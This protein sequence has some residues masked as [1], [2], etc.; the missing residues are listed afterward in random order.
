[1]RRQT[2]RVTR[3]SKRKEDSLTIDVF[4]YFDYLSGKYDTKNVEFKIPEWLVKAR[5]IVENMSD[6]DYDEWLEKAIKAYKKRGI[7]RNF[8]FK[9]YQ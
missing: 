8:K 6:D 3:K 4:D 9:T 7:Q 1:M 2:K 5:N